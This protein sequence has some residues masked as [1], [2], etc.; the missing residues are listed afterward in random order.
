MFEKNVVPLIVLP[1]NAAKIYS[2]ITEL[3][4]ND[5]EKFREEIYDRGLSFGDLRVRAGG[6]GVEFT[7][8]YEKTKDISF[9][10][11]ESICHEIVEQKELV[12]VNVERSKFGGRVSL[13]LTDTA[14]ESLIGVWCS[15]WSNGQSYQQRI[16]L[17]I[18]KLGGFSI[19][20]KVFS[21]EAMNMALL[22][23][24]RT[25]LET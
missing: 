16:F 7:T 22:F 2:Y 8:P 18:E 13:I 5:R 9:E 19:T 11:I 20:I 25:N 1:L 15:G 3:E 6:L 12:G 14:P 24:K 10:Q 21:L 4:K 17:E 23:A